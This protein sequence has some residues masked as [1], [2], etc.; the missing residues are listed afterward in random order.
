[1]GLRVVAFE[2]SEADGP[3]YGWMLDGWI[4]ALDGDGFDKQ[5]EDAIALVQ[6]MQ[7]FKPGA[8]YQK[9][10]SYQRCGSLKV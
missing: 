5:A 2:F 6:S 4:G 3:A 8:A 7:K 9:G 10:E 1:M